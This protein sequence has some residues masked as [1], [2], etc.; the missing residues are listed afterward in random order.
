MNPVR[1]GTSGTVADFA[2]ADSAPA[3]QGAVLLW[4]EPDGL[5]PGEP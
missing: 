3:V 1:A 2:V 4:L 5:G